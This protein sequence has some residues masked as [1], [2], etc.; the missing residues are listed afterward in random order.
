MSKLNQIIAVSTGKKTSAH[1]AVTEIYQKVQKA[2]LMSGLS[3]SYTPKFE[4]GDKLPDEVKHVQLKV[5]DCLKDVTSSYTELFDIIA[6]QDEANTKARADVVIDGEKL[7]SQAPVTFL[8]FLEKRLT[9]LHNIVEKLPTLDP[10]DRWEYSESIDCYETTPY[11]TAKTKKIL[12]NH[13]KSPATDKFPAQVETFSEDVVIGYYKT[14]KFSGAIPSK[15]KNDMLLRVRKVQDAVKHA[16]EQANATE[17]S[18]LKVSKPL[19]SY[20]FKI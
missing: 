4:D 5:M 16:R 13:E 15:E 9:E 19:F 2:D 20:L 12:K 8:L 11:E 7:F 17:V 14:K 3:R 10:A 6:T 18:H 1:K